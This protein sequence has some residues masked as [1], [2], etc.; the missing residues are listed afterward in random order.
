MPAASPSSPAAV[1]LAVEELRAT[2]DS[3]LLTYLMN[4][5]DSVRSLSLAAESARSSAAR[6]SPFTESYVTELLTPRLLASAIPDVSQL[7]ACLLCDAV[8]LHAEE[9]EVRAKQGL[10]F[11][12]PRH[13]GDSAGEV[14]QQSSDSITVSSA[15]GA[16]ATYASDSDGRDATST[17]GLVSLPFPRERCRDVLCCIGNC[18]AALM[19]TTPPQPLQ[20][21]AYVVERAASARVL[22]HLLPHCP[23]ADPATQANLVHIFAAVRCASS[24][25][26]FVST[27]SAADAGAASRSPGSSSSSGVRCATSAATCTE[28]AD[29]LRDVLISTHVITPAQLEPLLAELVAASPALRLMA[30]STSTTVGHGAGRASPRALTSARC[31][32]ALIAARV[33]L[34]QMDLLQPAITAWAAAEV[35]EGLAELAAADALPSD[36]ECNG[37]GNT[38]V[39]EADNDDGDDAATTAAMAAH[40]EQLN[41]RARGRASQASSAAGG[42]RRR[43]L[44]VMAHVLSV[45]VALMELHVDL[46]QQPLSTLAPLLEHRTAE[47]RL[48]ALRGFA[49]AFAASDAAVAA[50]R[51]VFLGP[52]LNR[53]LDVRPNIR[54]E[55]AR[56]SATLMQQQYGGAAQDAG[57][58]SDTARVALQRDVWAACEPFWERLLTDAHVLVRKQAVAAVTDAALAAAQLFVESRQTPDTHTPSSPSAFLARTLALRASDKN[59]RVRVAAVDGL[60]RLYTAYHLAWIPN[61]I[62]DGLHVDSTLTAAST[63]TASSTSAAAAAAAAGGSG[64][65]GAALTAEAV[66]EGLLPPPTGAGAAGA[67]AAMGG[68]AQASLTRWLS[69]A[70]PTPAPRPAAGLTLFDF[71]KESEQQATRDAFQ[72]GDALLGLGAVAAPAPHSHSAS[73]PAAHFADALVLLCQHLDGPHFTQLL[74]LYEKKPQL[75]LTVRRLFEF[76]AAVKASNGDVKSVEGQ[77]RIHAIHRLLVFLRDTTGAVKGEWDALFRAKDDV[78]RRSLLRACD[79]AYLDGIDARESLVR[80]LAGRVSPEEATFVKRHLAPQL[81]TPV[82]PAHVAELLRRLHRSIFQSARHEVAVDEDGAVGALRALLLLTAATPAYAA[83]CTSGLADA[84]RAAAQLAVGLPPRWCA[85]LLHALQQW[86][87]AMTRSTGDG[88][89]GSGSGSTAGGVID[90]LIRTLSDMA[91]AALPMQQALPRTS[92]AP[93]GVSTTAAA[94]AALKQL[95]KQATRTLVALRRVTAY[96]PHAAAALDSLAAAL[97]E[98]LV[99]RGPLTNDVKVVA[100]LASVKAL[101]RSADSATPHAATLLKVTS[102]TKPARTSADTATPA[103]ALLTSLSSLLNAAMTDTSDTAE[104][105]KM[106]AL[107]KLAS[108]AGAA[109][110]SHTRS[111]A[112][113]VVDGAAKALVALVALCPSGTTTSSSSGG[114]SGGGRVSAPPSP[115]SPAGNT[116]TRAAAVS[117]VTDALL[118]GYKAV[119]ASS[120]LAAASL[121]AC[122]RRLAVEQQLVKLLLTPSPDMAR[123]LAVAVVLSVE[124]DAQVR[125]VV[126]TKLAG[127]LVQRTCDMRVAALLLLTAIS[128]DNKSSFQRLRSLVEMVGDHLRA[129]QA[130]QGAS[131]SS[132]AAL[133]C[134]CEYA[135]P[136]LVLFLAHHPYYASEEADNQFTAFQRVWH[137]L[138][139]EL[140][141]HGTQCAGFVVE[142]LSKIKQADDALAPTS[143]AC[144]VMCDLAS[145][146]LLECLGQRQSRAEDLRRYPGAV[147]LPSFFVRTTR[148]NPQALLETVYLSDGVRVSANAPFRVPTSAS[149]G[150]GG[151]H[152]S[153]ASSRATTSRASSAAVSLER[154][155]ARDEHQSGSP[156]ASRRGGDAMVPS[157]PAHAGPRKRPRSPSV[158]FSAAVSLSPS[159]PSQTHVAV[160]TDD[161]DF[162]AEAAEEA[163]QGS[164]PPSRARTE[165]TVAE[166]ASSPDEGAP[167]GAAEAWEAKQAALQRL[168]IDA[169]LDDLFRGL[170]KGDIA[171]L[172]WKVVR[173]RLEDAL[174]ELDR[175][176]RL[177]T[178]CAAREVADAEATGKGGAIAGLTLSLHSEMEELLQYAKDQLRARYDRAPA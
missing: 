6:V 72:E 87:T 157:D 156:G 84:L 129:K 46:A 23:L 28:M 29:M 64:A 40:N 31:G 141:R 124:E 177:A 70:V 171:Q 169:A 125:H 134:Y 16:S 172:R 103:P 3:R 66:M 14:A 22:C 24:S 7:V 162:E 112:S 144:R 44:Q 118:Q 140:L 33:L 116:V 5:H 79:D 163:S 92:S 42:R 133:Y 165:P 21:L 59:R 13:R 126:Q 166:S 123:E 73:T 63:T 20:R 153:R 95:A 39:E 170:K 148:A 167:G 55:A 178:E 151:G 173:G 147:L 119:A 77:Q 105:S 52:F 11:S 49:A 54:T 25:T 75:R 56:F 131:L 130:S 113:A 102:N 104:R 121:G 58:T 78:V 110:L 122:Q 50:Y 159:A 8:R 4:M 117:L 12:L 67:A 150:G 97:W 9:E 145:R 89:G 106:K 26:S 91:L 146:V 47:V 107:L 34:G 152:G 48:L 115:A 109:P 19:D 76:H 85:L 174:G 15:S 38:N 1:R 94:L 30:P 111:I 80:A 65:S 154:E 71:E 2:P 60:T 18:F 62:L 101:A 99:Q 135:I 98:R 37:D 168:A 132:P 155:D 69:P 108:E 27:S 86:A 83:Q 51:A 138:I 57:V 82:Q 90:S 41:S 74:R 35:D 53:C 161:V 32:G 128:E 120:D 100:W 114:G 149:G 176:Q 36:D 160:G 17:A 61:A 45:L 137:L 127:H 93:A 88:S 142:L 175:Q 136:F 164:T 139:G 81:T 158:T 68:T 143:D 10:Q 43:G 96:T